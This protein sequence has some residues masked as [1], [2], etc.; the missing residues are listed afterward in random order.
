[1]KSIVSVLGAFLFTIFSE[2]FIR[3]IIIFY[4]KSEFLF[5]G[6]TPLPSSIWSIIIFAALL[7][8]YWLSG[9]LVVTITNFAVVKHLVSFATLLLLWR[10]NEYV[11]TDGMEPVWY[12]AIH[13]LIIPFSVYLCFLTYQKTNVK[14]HT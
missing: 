6:T 5:F 7:L 9:M 10:V 1:M 3:V 2:G 11:Q 13:L 14:S 8:I 12:Y 4:H